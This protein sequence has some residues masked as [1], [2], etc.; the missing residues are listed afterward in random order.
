MATTT[1]ISPSRDTQRSPPEIT[2]PPVMVPMRM[3]RKVAIATSALP[4]TSVSSSSSSGRMAY[5]AGPKKVDCIPIR[6]NTVNS[7]P[8][9][10][11]AKPTPANAMTPISHTLT[12]RI[13]RHFGNRSASC[14]A[15]AEKRKNGKMKIPAQATTMVFEP[16][17][18]RVI[19]R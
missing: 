14:P 9:L 17:P 4:P 11:V 12:H 7:R 13:N 10:L 3:A 16:S 8:R 15:V 1:T 19:E 18:S 2:N 5:F 6:N